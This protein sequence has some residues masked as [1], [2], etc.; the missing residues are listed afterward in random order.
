MVML[1]FTLHSL[2]LNLTLNLFHLQTPLEL[3]QLM[4][5]EWNISW[6][7]ST[8]NKMNIFWMLNYRCFML[9]WWLPLLQNFI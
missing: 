9:D 8:K 5:T 4:M 2:K 3:I 7:Y 6:K 1:R